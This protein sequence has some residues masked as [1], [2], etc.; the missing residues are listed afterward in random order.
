MKCI[1]I[2]KPVG[3]SLYSHLRVRLQEL[4]ARVENSPGYFFVKKVDFYANI[5]ST[6]V[7]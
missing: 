2:D 4:L 6:F 7:S 1:G 3:L 5:V